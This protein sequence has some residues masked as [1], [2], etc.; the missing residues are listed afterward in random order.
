LLSSV[1]FK[2]L[3][4]SDISNPAQARQNLGLVGAVGAGN[5][6]TI[7]NSFSG[8]T[9]EIISANASTNATPSTLVAYDSLGKITANGFTTTGTVACSSVQCSYLNDVNNNSILTWDGVGNTSTQNL[10]IN[11]A[12]TCSSIN[13]NAV[14][15]NIGFNYNNLYGISSI[16]C[17]NLKDTGNHTMLSS[18]G[19]GSYTMN[20]TLS[21]GTNPIACGALTCSSMVDSSGG[22]FWS[23]FGSA[24]SAPTFTTVGAITSGYMTNPTMSRVTLGAASSITGF[25]N[26]YYNISATF[27]Y[28]VINTNTYGISVQLRA[29]NGSTTRIL[30]E[31]MDG[32]NTSATPISCGKTGSLNVNCSL[33]SSDVLSI[34]IVSMPNVTNVNIGGNCQFSGVLIK[35]LS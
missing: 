14:G 8:T 25:A 27:N 5:Y 30:V 4:L 2:G 18:D 13:T 6:L 32:Y 21:L 28:S 3:N 17:S 9:N 16:K 29:V 31:Y 10:I 12:L 24:T 33:T 15:V 7:T 20:G 1:L 22:Y 11:G 26:G 34:N 19:Y 35:Q 23:R